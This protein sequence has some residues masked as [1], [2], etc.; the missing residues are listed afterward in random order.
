MVDVALVRMAVPEHGVLTLMVRNRNPLVTL[1]A[2]TLHV[3]LFHLTSLH[4]VREK[5]ARNRR[6]AMIE[7]LVVPVG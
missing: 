3:V 1:V 2:K 6:N 5:L 4:G 7:L